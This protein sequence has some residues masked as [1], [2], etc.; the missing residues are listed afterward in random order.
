MA[1]EAMQRRGQLGSG[2]G[3]AAWVEATTYSSASDA[4]WRAVGVGSPD[5]LRGIFGNP[6]RPI[7]PDSAWRTTNAVTLAQTMSDTR[8]FTAMPLLADRLEEVGCPK[9]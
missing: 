2:A 8:D 7:A 9:E 6:F 3:A 1:R 5:F 4:A